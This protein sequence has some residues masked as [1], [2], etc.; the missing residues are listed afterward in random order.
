MC[1][2]SSSRTN[3]RAGV[4]RRTKERKNGSS[5]KAKLQ[6][7]VDIFNGFFPSAAGSSGLRAQAGQVN[8]SVMGTPQALK[9]PSQFI[10]IYVYICI[11][12]YKLVK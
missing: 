9:Q 12:R 7:H 5:R 6:F 3:E 8:N 10:N 1:L 11:Y 2:Q 4:R